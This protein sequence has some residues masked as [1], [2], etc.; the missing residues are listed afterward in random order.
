MVDRRDAQQA[1]HRSDVQALVKSR[2]LSR[3][4]RPNPTDAPTEYV[5]R[6][7]R[8]G[9]GA[10][11]SNGKLGRCFRIRQTCPV[12]PN[13]ESLLPIR[14]GEPFDEIIDQ[15]ASGEVPKDSVHG[16]L[17][18]CEGPSSAEFPL[19]RSVI[20]RVFRPVMEFHSAPVP[21]L[22]TVPDINPAPSVAAP[23]GRARSGGQAYHRSNLSRTNG[24]AANFRACLR[25]PSPVVMHP[26]ETRDQT[27]RCR[28]GLLSRRPSEI[29]DVRLNCPGRWHCAPLCGSGGSSWHG[30][31]MTRPSPA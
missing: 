25:I 1:R 8:S 13:R 27:S 14:L 15:C 22:S 28:T 17:R 19:L 4:D 21:A 12:I 30:R 3:S 2:Q 24:L 18:F 23:H 31:G 11:W 26:D 29:P 7:F 16:H 6:W 10:T 5:E 9:A 20:G